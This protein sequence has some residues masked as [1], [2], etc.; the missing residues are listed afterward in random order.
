MSVYF[1]DATS[2]DDSR[3]GLSASL[4]WQTLAKVNGFALQPGDVVRLKRGETWREPLVVPASGTAGSPIRF[5]AYGIGVPPRIVAVP[6]LTAVPEETGGVFTSGFEDEVDALT[7]DFTGK[8]EAGGNALS[9]VTTQARTGA[10]AL[11][12][13]FAGSSLVGN[14]YKT[15]ASPATDLYARAWIRLTG[16]FAMSDVGK[17]VYLF[18]L[19]DNVAPG[20]AF[21]L[22]INTVNRKEQ[23]WLYGAF[24]RAGGFTFPITGQ[25]V[26][27]EAW[28]C[29]EAHWV[30]SAVAGGLQVWFDGVSAGSNFTQDTSAYS[31]RQLFIGGYTGNHPPAAGSV[32]FDDVK[33]S[34]TGP[35][36]DGV[37][38]QSHCIDLNGHDYVQ[39]EG[40]DLYHAG[41][42]SLVTTGSTG[43]VVSD[44]RSMHAAPWTAPSDP[45]PPCPLTEL[46]DVGFAIGGA[47]ITR[48]G[49]MFV[50]DATSHV[51]R[52][53]DGGATWANVLVFPDVNVSGSALFIDT[54][55]YIHAC[56]AGGASSSGIWTSEDDGE[57]WTRN[58]DTSALAQPGGMWGIDEDADGRVFAGY[59][60][61]HAATASA[62]IYRSTDGRAWT[63]VWDGVNEG[64][65]ARH[66]HGLAVDKATGYVY[67]PIGDGGA[68][69]SPI[70][71]RSTDH[72]A[73]WARILPSMPQCVG[74]VC[75][76]G[77]R[78]FGT[79]VPGSRACLYR[80]TDD[81]TLVEVLAVPPGMDCLWLRI[82][83]ATGYC[84]AG[85]GGA[86]Q[87]SGTC[88]VWLSEDDGLTWQQ[89]LALPIT[90]AADGTSYAS[91][92]A[93]TRILVSQVAGGIAVGGGIYGLGWSLGNILRLDGGTLK[94]ASLSGQGFSVGV[95]P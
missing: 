20:Y 25:L 49:V 72:G 92:T 62:R 35:L 15:L 17:Q 18:S 36:G 22:G 90:A 64:I 94:T 13:A 45:E 77:F 5:G 26:T 42:V 69:A 79:D 93:S 11:R 65:S 84:Y 73:T 44:V 60:H 12:C 6:A 9:I 68:W 81:V 82:D 51:R 31:A 19:Y 28:H 2:G 91:N 52:S 7:T 71:V 70:T 58:L 37:A 3:S 66:V 61:S 21:L 80:T 33:L 55:G 53:T 43:A 87:T 76:N 95:T 57:T 32:Y 24:Q 8:N 23:A 89:V 74:V 50:H 41:D 29:L 10:K 83:P 27:P 67:A 4:A 75:G 78:L 56:P 39:V 30:Q 63:E 14:A 47:C 88:G 85:F 40:L 86:T 46:R 48:G 34:A 38:R 59:Y 16:D 54:R 1:I